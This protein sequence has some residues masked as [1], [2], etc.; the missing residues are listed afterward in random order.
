MAFGKQIETLRKMRGWTMEELSSASGVDVGTINAIEKRDSVRSKDAVE[1][2][3]A[4]GLTVEDLH[5]GRLYPT[6]APV[7]VLNAEEPSS[8]GPA[9]E[10]RGIVPLISW[11]Q[12]GDWAHAADLLST[13]DAMEWIDTSVQVRPH[14]FAL[15]VVGDSM[16]PEFSPGTILVVEPDL[17]ANPGDYVIAKNGDDEATFKQLV[18]DGADLYLKPLN[19]RY[20]IKLLGHA[21]II[22]VVRE[23]VKR[24]R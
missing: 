20:P 1:L 24:Y 5:S 23:A 16:E 19:P 22:G 13:G 8:L 9:P 18:K 21:L 7:T 4:F 2:A 15:R 11:V 10:R 12:A 17:D 14:T 3:A 6:T